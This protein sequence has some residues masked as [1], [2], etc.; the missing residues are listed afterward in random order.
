LK[1]EKFMFC[2]QCGAKNED[3][4]K[5]CIKC[6]ARLSSVSDASYTGGGMGFGLES[7]IPVMVSEIKT[8]EKNIES[9]DYFGDS[10]A[11]SKKKDGIKKLIAC[12]VL[13]AAVIALVIGALN[14]FKSPNQ[15][16]K[17]D[18]SKLPIMYM[19][20]SDLMVK[21]NGNKEPYAM[22]RWD[23]NYYDYFNKIKFTEDGKTIFFADNPSNIDFRLYYRKVDEETPKGKGADS[24]GVRIASGV[25]A[26]QI[27]KDGKFVL[28]KRNDR[29]YYNDLKNEDRIL[30]KD[31]SDFYLSA[32]EKMVVYRNLD[33]DLY[34]C[35]LGKK[36]KPEK[37][38]SGVSYLANPSKNFERLYYIKDSSLYRK[39]KGKEKERIA[40]DV[41]SAFIIGEEE[42]VIKRKDEFEESAGYTL[43]KIENGK[44]TE[45]TDRMVI[46]MSHGANYIDQGSI[47]FTNA[48]AFITIPEDSD[49]PEFDDGIRELYIITQNNPPFKAMDIE[50]W[51][52]TNY[53]FSDDGKYFYMIE[54]VDDETNAGELYRYTVGQDSLNVKT[55][56]CDEVNSYYVY[57]NKD[58]VTRLD[59]DGETIMG[60]YTNEKY[61]ELS[62]DAGWFQYFNGTLYYLDDYSDTTFSSNLMRFKNSKSEEIDADV[63]TFYVRNENDVVYIKDF[64][65]KR[66]YGDLYHKRGSSKPV[67]VDT[68]VSD[69]IRAH[70]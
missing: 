52:A 42:Y 46:D 6:G 66:G 48:V 43:C 56:I 3:Y 64:S 23:S 39:E 38:D 15:K 33:G 2:Q 61:Y 50:M 22:I 44:E 60:F 9:Y 49:Y 20:S 40:R 12:V 7:G 59:D 25:S 68:D 11:G 19:K 35:G 67:L 45:I 65:T 47:V 69:I 27:Q 1:G 26:F 30:A 55:K 10:E 51:K 62:E 58:V 28:Y 53:K 37:I 5:F 63:F 16:S 34:M 31:V 24:I 41:L 14:I 36:D 29:L 8:T 70:Y 4:S 32:D 57:N 21:T 17:Y 13:A 18:L 54:D